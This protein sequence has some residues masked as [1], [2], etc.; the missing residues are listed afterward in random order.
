LFPG[1][2]EADFT[3]AFVVLLAVD[4]LVEEL[5]VVG[6]FGLD[7]VAFV[8]PTL[9][10]GEDAFLALALVAFLAVD[11]VVVVA[12]FLGLDVAVFFAAAFLAVVALLAAARCTSLRA[13]G[14]GT[15]LVSPP[16]SQ[17]TVIMG[18]RTAVMTPVRGPP[19]DS[20]AIRSPISDMCMLPRGRRRSALAKLRHCAT[21]L[22]TGPLVNPSTRR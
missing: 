11:F 14:P 15:M 1:A 5:F 16:L 17:S 20:K 12:A 7:F 13:P 3:V 21:P 9:L 8:V 4:F 19:L 6:F 2:F 22:V 10:D 18:L